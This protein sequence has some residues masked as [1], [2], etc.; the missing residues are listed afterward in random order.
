MNWE[1]VEAKAKGVKLNYF[2]L[3]DFGK[4]FLFLFFWTVIAA[5]ESDAKR[6]E[7]NCTRDF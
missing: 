1:G 2:K 4:S 7:S 6:D 3:G 5:S